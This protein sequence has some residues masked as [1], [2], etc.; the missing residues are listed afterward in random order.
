MLI[1]KFYGYAK[2]NVLTM[3]VKYVSFLPPPTTSNLVVGCKA[4]INFLK[5]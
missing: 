3:N 5:K 2:K 4:D 1:Y